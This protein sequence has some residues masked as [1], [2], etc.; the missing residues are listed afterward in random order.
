R[1]LPGVRTTSRS[2]QPARGAHTC[3]DRRRRLMV[4]TA[5][6]ASAATLLL[7]VAI[8]FAADGKYSIKVSTAAAP[9]EL[10]EPFRKL[11]SDQQIQLLD[12]KGTPIGELWLRKDVPVKAA[13]D[14]IKN[15]VAYK[16]LEET[17]LLGA[18]RFNQQ[19]TDYR[20]QR[21]KSGVYT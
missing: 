20:K 21:I 4:R 18:I 11:L 10:K 6:L 13:A 15:G 1:N 12:P 14:Q 8:S 5:R 2:R 17:T 3:F 19:V 16:D 7:V 9:N